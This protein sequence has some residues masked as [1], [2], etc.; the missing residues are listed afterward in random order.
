MWESVF[1]FGAGLELGTPLP[2]Q[3]SQWP[4]Y[5]KAGFLSHVTKQVERSRFCTRS[6]QQ[7]ETSN[8]F[9][10][11]DLLFLASPSWDGFRCFSVLLSCYKIKV[12]CSPMSSLYCPL[13]IQ[14]CISVWGWCLNHWLILLLASGKWDTQ[15]KCTSEAALLHYLGN[16]RDFVFFKDYFPESMRHESPE[17][18]SP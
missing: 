5:R 17:G 11:T 15:A 6:E 2:R 3:I 9:C 16:K 10:K 14:V 18:R 8:Y 13:E 12:L 4:R 1:F 7:F